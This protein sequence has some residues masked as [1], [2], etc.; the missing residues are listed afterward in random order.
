MLMEAGEQ[1]TSY[2]QCSFRADR[3]SKVIDCEKGVFLPFWGLGQKG[4][5][6]RFKN[7]GGEQSHLDAKPCI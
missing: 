6:A 2:E 5:A 7:S 3:V 4:M 1:I